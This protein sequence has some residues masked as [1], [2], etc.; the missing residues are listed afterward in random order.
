MKNR[1]NSVA[2]ESSQDFVVKE[3]LLKQELLELQNEYAQ[4]KQVKKYTQEISKRI[5]KLEKLIPRRKETMA[6]IQ[7]LKTLEEGQWVRNGST[8]PGEIKELRITGTVPEV[9]VQWWKGTVSTPERPRAL[10]VVKPEDMKYV[11]NGDNRS[12][13]LIRKIDSFECEDVEV[14]KQKKEIAIVDKESLS[15]DDA[16][17]IELEMAEVYQREIVYCQKRIE[18]ISAQ[19]KREE[20]EKLLCRLYSSAKTDPVIR[21]LEI[22][23]IIC[24]PRCQQ[25]EQLDSEVVAEYM[26]VWLSGGSLPPVKVIQEGEDHW[27]YDGFHTLQSA[28]NARI[29]TLNAEVTP[30]AFRDAILASVGVNA[31]HGL[32]R[33]NATKRNA[34]MTLLKD[35]EWSQWSDREIARQCK[36]H[37]STVSKIRKNLTGYLAS[38]TTNGDKNNLTRNVSSDAECVASQA[39]DLKSR[40]RRDTTN[41]DKD[42]LTNNVISDAECVAS[43]ALDLKSRERRDTTNGDKNNLTRNVSSDNEKIRTYKD[44]H[45][46]VSK[47]NIEQIG[48]STN[49]HFVQN[50]VR[51][52]GSPEVNVNS[53]N[54][55]NVSMMLKVGQIVQIVNSDR[56]DQRLVGYKNSY[57]SIT[58]KHEY[59][60]DLKIWKYEIENVSINDIKLAPLTVP[61][62]VN[63]SH[64]KLTEIMNDFSSLEDLIENIS[65]TRLDIAREYYG[66]DGEDA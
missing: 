15:G 24:D 12:P 30:G 57:A 22:K 45:G 11:W 29:T 32:R 37:H 21:D 8:K 48:N 62:T 66:I 38:D 3:N 1:I 53:E 64:E 17:S 58:A 7:Y 43:Q 26:E 19:N 36:V 47:M 23:Q 2:T 13:K 16:T 55:G 34:V 14:L 63:L 9:W 28:K 42:N 5:S 6:E 41:S 10:T 46:N 61:V 20:Q 33:S 60:V 51:N 44:K 35:E 31:N 39:L 59:S 18:S 4:L 40:E 25:R 56:I 54:R 52:I 49:G 50:E 27:L 65:A